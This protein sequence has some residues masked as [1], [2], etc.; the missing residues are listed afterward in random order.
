M[1]GESDLDMDATDISAGQSLLEDVG[2]PPTPCVSW[3]T[4]PEPE[5]QMHEDNLIELGALQDKLEALDKDAVSDMSVDTS[6]DA[7]HLWQKLQSKKKEIRK[8]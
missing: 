2:S 5:L 1:S 3:A 8:A 4:S 7:S 6:H